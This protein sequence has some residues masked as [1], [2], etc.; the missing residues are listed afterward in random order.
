MLQMQRHPKGEARFHSRRTGG[1]HAAVG[2]R[3]L[4]RDIEAKSRSLRVSIAATS[5]KRLEQP[6]Y[7]KGRD[8]SSGIGD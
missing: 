5:R 4:G 8:G 2:A 3:N 7:R 1:Q 6:F